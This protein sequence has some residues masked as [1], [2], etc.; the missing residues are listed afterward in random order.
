[1]IIPTTEDSISFI[2]EWFDKLASINRQYRL[3]YYPYDHSI[4]IIDLKTKKQAL[5]RIKN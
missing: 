2:V 3:M 5:K 4:E 1:M